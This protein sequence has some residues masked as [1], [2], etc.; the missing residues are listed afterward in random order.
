MTFEDQGY[1]ILLVDD[2]PDIHEVTR[3]ALRGK[4]WRG[5]PL[6]LESALSAEEAREITQREPFE[7]ALVDVVMETDTAGLDLCRHFRRTAPRSLR[8]ILRTGQPGVAPEEAVLNDFDIDYYASKAEI[9]PEKL[10]LS[11]RACIRSSLDIS[12]LLAASRYT[13]AMGR[14]SEADTSSEELVSA[15]HDVLRFL[16]RKFGVLFSFAHHIDAHGN[17]GS[18]YGGA[19][20][21][22]VPLI[23][24][25]LKDTS[26]E[27][28]PTAGE[29]LG[30]SESSM[31]L[32]FRS[33]RPE[34]K[35][36][37]SALVWTF[38]NPELRTQWGDELNQ[39]L[40]LFVDPLIQALRAL[41]Y[42]KRA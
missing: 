36:A 7:V 11:I 42:P 31:A 30:L 26:L 14:A 4:K 5:L 19:D 12:T 28:L 2:E 3:L 29:S 15:F 39:D 16:E 25:F 1:R 32:Y 13:V 17:V 24:R 41:S 27:T 6:L 22:W 40:V 9:T 38:R 21:A 37:R 20:I 8:I 34:G 23:E 10:W 33:E 18:R 35:E